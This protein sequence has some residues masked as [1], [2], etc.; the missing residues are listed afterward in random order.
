MRLN[1]IVIERLGHGSNCETSHPQTSSLESFFTFESTVYLQ[2]LLAELISD[3]YI[4]IGNSDGSTIS[5]QYAATSPKGLLAVVALAPHVYI[6]EVTVDG[7]REACQDI[8]K[9]Q[10]K[11][12]SFHDEPTILIERWQDLWTPSALT[13]SILDSVAKI[14]CPT[15]VVQGSED[16]FASMKQFDSMTQTIPKVE[17][18]TPHA[19]HFLTARI[20]DAL[21]E[22][23]QIFTNPLLNRGA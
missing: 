11:I 18:W 16:Q 6:E 17:S 10:S 12:A 15:L 7:V 3:D 13:W 1:G 23:I 4:L 9:L 22:K 2:S 19:D 14:P 20:P 5:L 21:H 8:E